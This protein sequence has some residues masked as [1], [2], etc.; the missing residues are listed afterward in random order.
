MPGSAEDEELSDF[1]TGRFVPCS[2]LNIDRFQVQ[3]PG[4]GPLPTL[5]EDEELG[6]AATGLAGRLPLPEFADAEQLPLSLP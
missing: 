6:D 2:I 3:A 4:A 5:D 1:N